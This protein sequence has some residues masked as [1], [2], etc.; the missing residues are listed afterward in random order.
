[1]HPAQEQDQNPP[2]LSELCQQ[3]REL[4]DLANKILEEY[5]ENIKSAND[6][7]SI[8]PV[9]DNWGQID[10][11][12]RRIYLKKEDILDRIYKIQLDRFTDF[13]KKAWPTV[14]GVDIINWI[15]ENAQIKD[16]KILVLT[17]FY[18]DDPKIDFL[19]ENLEVQGNLRI[20]N[21]GIIKIPSNLMVTG[22]ISVNK[23]QKDIAKALQ[24]TGNIKGKVFVT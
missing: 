22:N 1:M 8:I 14:A 9:Q 5:Q 20:E 7:E 13:L 17:D 15:A 21:S 10:S 6:S 3:A 2:P 4:I 23:E 24:K 16:N 19:P 12:K 18:I 11:L